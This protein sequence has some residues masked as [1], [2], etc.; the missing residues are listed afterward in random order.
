M[1]ASSTASLREAL[2]QRHPAEQRVAERHAHVAQ[3]RRVG[4]VALPARDRQLLGQVPQQ[5]VGEPEVALGVL[6]V[7]RVDLVRHRRRAD[8]ALLHPL[9]EVA[10]RDVAPDVAVEVDQD[11]VGAGDRVEELGHV[12]VRLDLRRVRIE[13][14][15]EPRDDP[16][17]RAAPSRRPGYATTCAL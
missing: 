16:A 9:P 14:E 17:R 3:H 11:G 1:R 12:V 8:L 15:A 2:P 6:E 10:E 13:L 7:D 5:R 4:E